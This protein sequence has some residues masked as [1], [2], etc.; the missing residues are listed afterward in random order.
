MSVTCLGQPIVVVNNLHIAI[1]LLDKKS[2]IYSDRPR[3]PVAGEI[4]GW[5]RMLGLIPY[6]PLWRE[7]RRLFSQTLGTRK[8][9]GKL[10]AQ[11]EREGQ[12]LLIDLLQEPEGLFGHVRRYMA[13]YSSSRYVLKGVDVTDTPLVRYWVSRTDTRWSETMTNLSSSSTRPWKPSRYN[14]LRE[15]ALQMCCPCVSAPLSFPESSHATHIEPVKHVPA[16]FPGAEWKRQALLRRLELETVCEMPYEFTKQQMVE[17][18][19]PAAFVLL[20]TC[21]YRNWVK[22]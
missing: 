10:T 6:G 5:E 14:L 13:S 21:L 22:Q 17:N 1:D 20:M 15:Q 19:F 8:S 16:W 7:G 2:A 3:F 9:L 4:M 12:R 18:I 11:L